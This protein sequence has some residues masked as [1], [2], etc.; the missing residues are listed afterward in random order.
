MDHGREIPSRLYLQG[1]YKRLH[2]TW[3]SEDSPWKASQVMSILMK[4]RLSVT[5]VC[6]V[7]C[8]AGGVLEELHREM[9]D[10]AEF[11]GY[12]ISPQAI[13]LCQPRVK[14]RLQ[15]QIHDIIDDENAFFDLVLALDVV[16][17]VENYTHFLRVLRGK[18]RFKIVTI[19]L[20]LNVLSILRRLPVRRRQEFG[21]INHFSKET[22]LQ[23]LDDCGYHIIDWRYIETAFVSEP[24]SL[25]TLLQK[26][27]LRIP[28]WFSKDW[29]VRL[30]GGHALLVL[31]D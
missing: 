13:E 20:E 31:A 11:T 23:T 3:C 15:F 1:G 25:S 6:D 2:P 18:G 26:G 22:A 8:G 12:D 24:A 7:G 29:G 17:H 19:P 10:T 28:C 14:P 4:N 21:H 27:V 5:R 9:P 30:L 16:E